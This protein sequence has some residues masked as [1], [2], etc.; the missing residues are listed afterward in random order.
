MAIKEKGTSFSDYR[1]PNGQKGNFGQFL[2]VY[3]R[4][5]QKCPRCQHLIQTLK[6]G[7]RTAH[8]CPNCQK[9]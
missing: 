9:L 6:I 3:G 8:Y 5:N 2:K 4:Q 1:V 7:S